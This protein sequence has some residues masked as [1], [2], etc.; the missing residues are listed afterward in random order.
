MDR[1]DLGRD[2]RADHRVHVEVAIPGRSSADPDDLVRQ[3][4]RERPSIRVR[5]GEHGLDAEL[6]AGPDH[7]DGDFPPVSDQHPTKTTR[8]AHVGAP[9]PVTAAALT[10]LPIGFD[11]QNGDKADTKVVRTDR[12]MVEVVRTDRK[13]TR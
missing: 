7:P 11:H 5:H 6:P 9:L 12:K 13:I 1:V 10:R 2:R 3:P 8:T 4:G